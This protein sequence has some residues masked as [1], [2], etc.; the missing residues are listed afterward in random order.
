M[1]ASFNASLTGWTH[2]W[3]KSW[4]IS[5]NWG[6]VILIL[7]SSPSAKAATS[8]L[9]CWVEDK[10]LLAFS[11]T[12][13]N[14]L[15][16]F[17]FLLISISLWLL[18]SSIQNFNKALSKSSP[19]KWVSPLVDLTSNNWPSKLKTETSKVPPPKS[20]TRIFLSVLFWLSNP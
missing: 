8:I 6:L 19:P 18:N 11:Q 20:K 9:V 10:S 15:K 2:F 1:L 13:F 14:L 17:W 5:S 12:T 16:A 3:N 7:K 4:H